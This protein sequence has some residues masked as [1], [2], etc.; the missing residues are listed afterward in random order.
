MVA[1]RN[2]TVGSMTVSA[3]FGRDGAGWCMSTGRPQSGSRALPETSS[4][5]VRWRWRVSVGTGKHALGADEPERRHQGEQR[6]DSHDPPAAMKR[7][8]TFGWRG[9]RAD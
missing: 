5:M 8:D 7:D 6:D 4:I 1:S 9:G 2:L 3:S